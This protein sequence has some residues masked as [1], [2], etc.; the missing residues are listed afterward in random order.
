MGRNRRVT[1]MMDSSS[2][3]AIKQKIV[4]NVVIPDFDFSKQ[5]FQILATI[6]YD[7]NFTHVFASQ[8][9]V[10]TDDEF[11][12]QL[13]PQLTSLMDSSSFLQQSD[14]SIGKDDFLEYLDYNDTSNSS[15]LSSPIS[16]IFDMSSSG[17]FHRDPVLQ[18]LYET[19]NYSVKAGVSQGQSQSPGEDEST[20]A[21]LWSIYYNRF[22]LLG[23]HYK[24]LKLALDFFQWPLALTPK[25]FLTQ[26]VHSLPV[27]GSMSIEDKMRALLN[28]NV[29]YKMRV[30]VSK[31]GNMK[32][33]AHELPKFPGYF[34]DTHEYIVRN[35]LSG[36]LD[37]EP[38]WDVY[39]N[40]EP[41]NVSPFTT[42][43]TTKREHYNKARE[44]MEQLKRDIPDQ[45]PKSEILVYNNLYQLMEGSITNVA[46]KSQVGA[47]SD[48]VRYTTPYLASGCLCGV[49]RYFL[50]RKGLLQED[51]IDIRDLH[52]GDE[53]IL[54]NG[55]MGCVKGVIRNSVDFS[56]V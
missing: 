35:L 34:A 45:R 50:L 41:I 51:A 16:G 19:V 18:G 5:E 37:G 22:F 1:A 26:L 15:V 39:I 32:I 54:F 20:D 14:D 2:L 29:S 31:D 53:I 36:F 56:G 33:E 7:P 43:K 46:V 9:L 23:E 55:I 28:V 52:L 21:S 11:S 6:R 10:E 30:L 13:D 4:R 42:F 27:Q 17:V 48:A 3:D 49:T 24:R 25:V 47:D 8:E 40:T 44:N 12:S 38:T